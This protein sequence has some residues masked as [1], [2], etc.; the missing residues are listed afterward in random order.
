MQ[1]I[2]ESKQQVT[3]RVVGVVK[4]MVKTYGGSLLCIDDMMPNTRKKYDAFAKA[5]GLSQE[6]L[7]KHYRVFV[8]YNNQVPQVLVK[9]KQ[10]AA[11]LEHKR[12]IVRIT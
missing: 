4:K 7:L 10:P 11:A 8:P 1:T 12:L 9:S 2:N 5:F 6:N 3:G